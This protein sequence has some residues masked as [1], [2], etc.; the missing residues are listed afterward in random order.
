LDILWSPLALN[1]LRQI[2]D[3][4]ATD[5]PAAA[6]KIRKT[7]IE[8][9]GLLADYPELGRRSYRLSGVRDLIIAGTEYIAIYGLTDSAINIYALVHGK[10]KWPE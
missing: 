2:H 9:I 4:I 3:Y 8:R 6:Y 5:N 7:I 10:R 1:D